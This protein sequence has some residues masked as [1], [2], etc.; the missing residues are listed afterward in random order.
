MRDFNFFESFEQKQSR[1]QSPRVNFTLVIA[2]LVLAAALWPAWNFYQLSQLDNQIESLDRQ[3]T[4]DPRYPLFEDVSDKE[5][6]L[7]EAQTQLEMLKKS[8]EMIGQR[9]VITE[10]VL[11]TIATAMPEDTAL[12]SMTIAGNS[13]QMQGVARSKPAIAELEYN[14]RGTERFEQIF[15]PSMSEADGLWTFNLAFNIK[16]GVQ[17]EAD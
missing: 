1:R 7:T 8:T 17:N 3:L 4:T 6:V 10:N 11:F 13:V 14:L 2:L 5:A 15:I 16:G 12:N 9:E